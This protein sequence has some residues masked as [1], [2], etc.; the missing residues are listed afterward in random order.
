MYRLIKTAVTTIILISIPASALFGTIYWRSLGGL[1]KERLNIKQELKLSSEK[2]YFFVDGALGRDENPGTE[3]K[4]WRTL[5]R[6]AQVEPLKKGTTVFVK[7]GTYHETLSPLNSGKPG[8]SLEFAAYPGHRVT[9]DG[10]RSLKEGMDLG[11]RS[12]ITVRGFTITRFTGDGIEALF[13]KGQGDVRIVDSEIYSNGGHG[14]RLEGGANNAVIGSKTYDNGKRGIYTVEGVDTAVRKN[15]SYRNLDED[16][17]F[18]G[19]ESGVIEGNI[20]HDQLRS[21]NPEAH[22]DGLQ[23]YRPPGS[24]NG[25]VL[26]SR[27]IFFNIH[28]LPI[29]LE[30]YRGVRIVGN[31]IYKSNSV[32]IS[33]KASPNTRIV[34]NLIY[35]PRYGGLN[36]HKKSTG[37]RSTGNIIFE[38]G[39]PPYEFDDKSI[40]GFS[41]N[42]NLIS[43]AGSNYVTSL[44]KQLID[45]TKWRRLGFDR[46]SANARDKKKSIE[47]M[48]T[49]YPELPNK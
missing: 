44:D 9:L 45:F 21:T 49:K 17:I 38:A 5:S 18:F 6:A 15:E 39:S 48:L 30:N 10:R 41:S 11:D 27:N 36:I 23:L 2:A 37:C 3:E 29:M 24:T 19:D 34:D 12:H 20:L 42:R 35:R 31:V 26:I 43:E 32:G 46:N 28:N 4:P 1:I 14:I 47:T 40:A 7:R 13:K 33:I 22:I 16:A 8:A 25:S